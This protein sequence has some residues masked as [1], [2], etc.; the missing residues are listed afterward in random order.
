MKLHPTQRNSLIVTTVLILV[1]TLLLSA[2]GDNT[3]TVTTT[4]AASSIPIPVTTSEATTPATTVAKPTPTDL[5]IPTTVPH[6]SPTP[7]ANLVCINTTTDKNP[8]G[9]LQVGT[10]G[11][12]EAVVR[13]VLLNPGANEQYVYNKNVA[14]AL[15][16]FTSFEI[17]INAHVLVDKKN[18]FDQ[19][20]LQKL[21]GKKV[22]VKGEVFTLSTGRATFII[23][24]FVLEQTSQLQ[25]LSN[26]P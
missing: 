19:N 26:E 3:A 17:G 21:K 11:C 8:Y 14:V 13:E 9:S 24:G 16:L 22:R 25:D 20:S 7:T 6:P 12:V 4:G 5:P 18:L 10:Y 1:L 15:S 23:K 2:C